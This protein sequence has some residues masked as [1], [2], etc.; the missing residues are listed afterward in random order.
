MRQRRMK[1]WEMNWRIFAGKLRRFDKRWLIGS[2]NYRKF[3]FQY[4]KN[5]VDFIYHYF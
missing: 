2:E 1:D 4:S 3:E 5:T